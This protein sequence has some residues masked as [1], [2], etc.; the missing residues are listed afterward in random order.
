MTRYGRSMIASAILPLHCTTTGIDSSAS[1]P[2]S[3]HSSDSTSADT[4]ASSVLQLKGGMVAEDGQGVFQTLGPVR[5]K[6][7]RP[8][9]KADYYQRRRV[10][11]HLLRLQREESSL[12]SPLSSPDTKLAAVFVDLLQPKSEAYQPLFALGEWVST[13][14]SRIGSNRVVTLAAEFFVYS[15]EAYYNGS[16]SKRIRALQTK[17]KALRELQLSVLR[18][19]QHS[20]YDLLLAT[21]LHY[22]A[23]V[24]MPFR[25]CDYPSIDMCRSF[26]VLTTCIMPSTHLA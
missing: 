16:H 8:S 17:S 26:L 22:A 25:D 13:V 18:A 7:K 24:H 9:K 6:T 14:P 11:A 1:T 5:A 20:T 21:K 2:V 3:S 12:T 4:P 19:Q 15:S 23:E 10:Q